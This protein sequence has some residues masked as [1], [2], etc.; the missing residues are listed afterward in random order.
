MNQIINRA[1][2]WLCLVTLILIGS[3]PAPSH[4]G[5]GHLHG[6][7]GGEDQGPSGGA[8]ILANDA[9]ENLG[10]RTERA[11]P[12]PLVEGPTVYGRTDLLPGGRVGVVAPSAG[13]VTRV[14]TPPG[15]AIRRGEP[16]LIF[17]PLQVGA[18]QMTVASPVD[19]VIG[20]LHGDIGEGREAGS[21]LAA[22]YD[23]NR[24]G[25]VAVLPRPAA[26]LG[27]ELGMRARIGL[28]ARP[29][30]I[31]GKVV[32]VSFGERTGGD[33]NGIVTVA[34]TVPGEALPLGVPGSA[35]LVQRSTDAGIE[36]P[37][38]AIV[39]ELGSWAVFVRS[40]NR[41]ERR[42]VTLGR[43]HGPNVEV[44]TGLTD[45]DEVVVVGSYPL[46]YARGDDPA[47][48]TSGSHSGVP[49]QLTSDRAEIVFGEL[50]LH[51]DK[52]DLEL[53]LARDS[54]GEDPFRVPVSTTITLE[55]REP[56]R[57]ITLAP[58]DT[59]HNKDEA[60]TSRIVAG[61]T[62]YFVFPGES[63][64]DAAWLQGREFIAEV[65]L[66]S[67]ISGTRFTSG[68]ITLVPHHHAH[69]HGESEHSHAANDH[70][71]H[72]DHGEHAHH[73]H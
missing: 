13:T 11:T 60:G 70:G 37:R 7:S 42:A 5:G 47:V 71:E 17:S 54:S 18:G 63:G 15:M 73:H 72:H 55:V 29:G 45:G 24:V 32:A 34:P 20:E 27:V 41:F 10:I 25:F 52:G 53:W 40:G 9:I 50:K 19:G 51:D 43:T 66:S 21:T 61:Q 16:I 49:V 39:G 3:M 22:V 67:E 62:D 4:A 59:T 68:W 44:R 38:A 46:Q 35:I 36:L 26:E 8:L 65:R 31:E 48:L 30:V 14:V 28:E 69:E 64:A 57:R 33:R 1:S 6:Y 58:R 56:E 23:L 2:W 12:A